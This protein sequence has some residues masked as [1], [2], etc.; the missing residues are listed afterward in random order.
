MMEEK[1]K[2]AFDVRNRIRTQEM[3]MMAHQER[4]KSLNSESLIKYLR[5]LLNPR[6]MDRKNKK[7]SPMIYITA[8]KT[9]HTV[10]KKLEL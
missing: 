8:T 9:N 1:A 3:C 5:N 6:W 2:I 4:R 10:N 7:R